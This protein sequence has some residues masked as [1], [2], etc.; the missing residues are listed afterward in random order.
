MK[1][2]QRERKQCGEWMKGGGEE[3]E[4]GAREEE[5]EDYI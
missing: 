4:D 5:G 2:D 3:R 1:G